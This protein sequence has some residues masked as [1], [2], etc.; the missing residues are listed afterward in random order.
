M[1]IDLERLLINCSNKWDIGCNQR[2]NEEYAISS[3]GWEYRFRC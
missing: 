2:E 1:D 3:S